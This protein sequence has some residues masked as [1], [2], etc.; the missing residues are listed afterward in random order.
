MGAIYAL[1]A[2]G[3]ILIHRVTRV[4]NFA[5]PGFAMVGAYATY[6]LLEHSLLPYPMVYIVVPVAV[7]V[8][9]WSVYWIAVRRLEDAD[10]LFPVIATVFIAILMAAL[11]DRFVVGNLLLVPSVFSGGPL[12]IGGVLIGR[13]TIWILGAALISMV[14][15]IVVLRYTRAGAAIRALSS[16]VRGAQLVGFSAEAGYGL[17]WYIGGALGGLAGVLIAPITGATSAIS[18]ELIAP[19][20]VAAVIAGLDSFGRAVA[21]ALFLGMA[22]TYAAGYT[23]SAYKSATSLVVL[24]VALWLKRVRWSSWLAHA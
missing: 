22:E 20:F 7:G 19:V 2:T 13:D 8:L 16:S 1:I 10:P 5:Q 15:L 21:A 24:F 9:A 3:L 11:V 18:T 12:V 6:L 14:L 23:S 17:A 4:V